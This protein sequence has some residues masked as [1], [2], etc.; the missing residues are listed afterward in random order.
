MDPNEAKERAVEA[1]RLW[2]A[3]PEELSSY[4][5]LPREARERRRLLDVLALLFPNEP[6]DAEQLD[7]FRRLW[8]WVRRQ[9]EYAGYGGWEPWDPAEPPS[10]EFQ[11]QVL[12]SCPSLFE[13]GRHRELGWLTRESTRG[14]VIVGDGGDGHGFLFWDALAADMVVHQVDNQTRDTVVSSWTGAEA[15][16]GALVIEPKLD[17]LDPPPPAS[18]PLL[19]EETGCMVG[20][21][22]LIAACLGLVL[23]WLLA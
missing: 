23:W 8:A 12:D 18:A 10:G 6:P 9:T 13:G 20:C 11:E 19:A 22:L 17:E 21:A 4:R 7:D 14:W 3:S 5:D 15:I 1:R 16:L 2:A